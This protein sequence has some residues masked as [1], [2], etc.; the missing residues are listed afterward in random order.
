MARSVQP[1]PNGRAADRFRYPE[2][3]RPEE[4]RHTFHEREAQRYLKRKESR[5][6]PIAYGVFLLAILSI[7]C[8]T[9]T[10]YVFSKYTGTIL[11]GVY[12][13]R[14]SL[15]GMNARQATRLCESQAANAYFRPVRLTYNALTY[16]PVPRDIGLRYD[17]IATAQAAMD[18]GRKGSFFAQLLDRLPV[19]PSHTIS[20]SYQL[21]DRKLTTWIQQVISTRLSSPP[22]NAQLKWTDNRTIS[23]VPSKPGRQLDIPATVAAV[24]SALGYLSKQTRALTV[25]HLTPAI[26]DTDAEVV[27]NKVNGLLNHPP[28]IGIGKRVFVM[29]RSDFRH[30]FSFADAPKRR[31]ID[32]N[33]D[34]R[35]VQ[36]YVDTLA[37]TQIDR[38]PQDAKVQF[39]AGKVTMV[40][41]A[42]TGRRL[43]RVSAFNSLLGV[44]KKLKPNA[45]LRWPVAIL[46]PPVDQSNPA[47]LGITT[48]L[49]VGKTSFDGAGPSR[50]YDI[51]QIAHTIND[52][53]V[54]PNEDISFNDIVGTGWQ[55]QV[56]ADQ[57]QESNGTL[58]PGD[59]GAM[60]QM[61]T[62]FLRALYGAGLAL[63]ERYS[64][65]YRLPWYEPPYG[66]D[67]VVSPARGWDLTFHNNTGRNLILETRVEPVQHAVYVYVYGP[68]LG[69]SVVV[70]GGKLSKIT[71]PPAK[72][73]VKDPSLAPDVLQHTSFAL[74][75]GT[76][77]L[78]R[79]VTKPNGKVIPDELRT[80]YQPHQAVDTVGS[81]AAEPTA[82][83]NASA[84]G[85]PGTLTPT[86][87][88][89]PTF[90]H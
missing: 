1:P 89:T 83:P 65:T 12:V 50:L 46:K 29:H 43:D 17:C 47:D 34:P 74:D 90:S 70:D 2:L 32:M 9:Y 87:K 31:T 75:G 21:D 23:L 42:H 15:G 79:L 27:L 33:V 7:F 19:H 61:A 63:T 51:E 36:S 85:T 54:R 24:H 59:G 38:V 39:F 5:W 11:P 78:Q 45:R 4:R 64:H 62:T 10:S 88:P 58:V 53:L 68:N 49:N 71:T 44:I 80:V 25:R 18:V 56:Y 66:Y 26:R 40:R 81:S 67:A 55:D 13:D 72:K 73:V 77:V 37:S 41:R 52:T 14:V 28:V 6:A 22:I 8:V 48:L 35:A 20:L 69:W 86:P 84:T 3:N 60:Q 16:E 30:M 76:A 57:V 82:T